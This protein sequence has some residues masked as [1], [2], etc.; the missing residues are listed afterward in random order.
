MTARS[1]HRIVCDRPLDTAKPQVI[2]YNGCRLGLAAEKQVVPLAC[3]HLHWDLTTRDGGF[4]AQEVWRDVVG[5]EGF[6]QVSNLGRVRSLDRRVQGRPDRTH[7]VRGQIKAPSVRGDYLKAGLYK[8]GKMVNKSVHRLVAEA[9]LE[10][11]EGKDYVDHINGNKHDN[12]AAN[13]RWVTMSENNHYA[14]LQG[15]VDIEKRRQRGRAY[16]A[17]HGTPTKPKPVIRSDGAVF[18][19][20]SAAARAL[21]TGQGNISRVL[22]GKGKTCKGY[23]FRYVGV[24]PAEGSQDA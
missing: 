17:E 6:Y 19:S 7:F 4:M 10:P 1:Q 2:G 16:V 24:G 13:L 20:I 14:H 12:R 22:L 8:D 15:L 3:L 9:F 21:N 5:Y 11:V 23:S 18:E